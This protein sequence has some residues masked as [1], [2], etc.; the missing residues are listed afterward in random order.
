[1]FI[2][3]PCTADME[4]EPQQDANEDIQFVGLVEKLCL[5]LEAL[6]IFQR[7]TSATHYT[8]GN[9]EDAGSHGE[10]RHCW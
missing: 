7:A 8:S 4:P 2:S 6:P 3:L 9:K 10:V 5:V 1:M